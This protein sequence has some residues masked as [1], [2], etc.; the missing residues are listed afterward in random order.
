VTVAIVASVNIDA[1]TRPRS[2]ASQRQK[3]KGLR[4][5]NA[6]ASK[7]TPVDSQPFL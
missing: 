7:V 2:C 1:Q 4:V 3:E 5:A 6:E